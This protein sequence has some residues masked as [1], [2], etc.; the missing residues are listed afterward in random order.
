M[1]RPLALAVAVA[2]ASTVA[3]PAGAAVPER[4]PPA[5]GPG[6]PMVHFG[7]EHLDDED[8]ELI[9]P[10]VVADTIGW[11]PKLVVMSGD[12]TSDGTEQNLLAWK[13]VMSAY[14]RAG[15]PYFAALGNHD[16]QALPGFQKGI[17]PL[18][19]LG[20][21]LS[22]F[23]DRPYPFGDSPPP[24]GFSPSERPADDPPGA[25]SHYAFSFGGVRWIILDNSCFEFRQCDGS[26]NP[27]FEDGN[28]QFGFLAEQGAAAE[29]AGELAF[30]DLH[31]PTQ[32]P[33]PEHTQPTP[34]PHTFGEGAS[35]ENGIFEDAAAR[36]GIDGVF[37]G[38]IKGQWVYEAQKV[39]YFIDGGAGG[40][41]YVDDSREEVGVDYGYWHGWRLLRIADGRIVTD[42]VPV[43]IPGGITVTP[44]ET[45]RVG[46]RVQLEAFGHQPTEEGPK[47]EH[48]ELRDPDPRRPNIANLPEPARIWT[49]SNPR[50][51]R[52]VASDSDDPRRNPR[53]Q[54]ADGAFVTTCPGRSKI[55]ITSGIESASRVLRVA[56]RRGNVVRRISAGRAS[57]S[58][59]LEQPAV[60]QVR[61]LRG[62]KVVR[63]LRN[64][65]FAGGADPLV[66]K[67]GR[68]GV[69]PGRYT[70]KVTV[71]SDRKPVVR[72]FAVRVRRG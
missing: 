23:A 11:A 57:V 32:D 40:E 15:I 1:R 62:G 68:R 64:R 54:T 66:T 67:F 30:V 9:L 47:V 60:V 26:Q 43:F 8:G 35:L 28:T 69:K 16:R 63:T 19:P 27:P 33:R 41:V 22:V 58:V 55:T 56:G 4:W 46:E 72:R 31:M 24:A 36:A 5:T 20:P 25:S 14:D 50:V 52:A 51:A 42:A 44:P 13:E 37:A 3:A 18:S 38:H 65:C 49:S 71:R 34:A 70:A 21:Y 53:T 6:V 17:S 39:R 29:K 10:K 61:L 12:K 48:L 45:A 59:A 2:A 7:E